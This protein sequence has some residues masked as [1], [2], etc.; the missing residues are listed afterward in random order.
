MSFDWKFNL[1]VQVPPID[2]AGNHED[3][4]A[5]VESLHEIPDRTVGLPFDLTK[6]NV[7]VSTVRSYQHEGHKVPFVY[8]ACKYHEKCPAAWRISIAQ[9]LTIVS[10]YAP[11]FQESQGLVI[12]QFEKDHGDTVT[13]E[14]QNWQVKKAKQEICSS[15][16]GVTAEITERVSQDPRSEQTK[17]QEVNF[18]PT[19]RQVYRAQ[20]HRNALQ[21]HEKMSHSEQELEAFITGSVHVEGSDS[22]TPYTFPDLCSVAAVTLTIPVIID[23]LLQEGA[24]YIARSSHLGLG[25]LVTDFTHDTCFQKYKTGSIGHLI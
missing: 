14:Q 15:H 2:P 6:Q 24:D 7:K 25:T 21:K 19:E 9:K 5:N 4:R 13:K 12:E 23:F 11:N 22:C 16:L 8:V 20:T 1:I 18:L 3:M 10:K 17:L